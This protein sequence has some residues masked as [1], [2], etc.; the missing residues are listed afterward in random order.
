V[1]LDPRSERGDFAELRV[2]QDVAASLE[3]CAG[4]GVHD[5]VVGVHR[6]RNELLAQ[7]PNRLDRG[8]LA[9]AGYGIG[10]EE[11]ARALRIDHAL[12][13]HRE[14]KTLRRDVVA[15]AVRDGAVVPERCPAPPDR[16]EDCVFARDAEHRVLLAG[17]ARIGQVLGRCR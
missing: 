10:G 14:S 13:D 6:S 12:H 5:E 9:A 15:L 3:D 1:L 17:E 2:A 7:A 4:S 8:A 16:I 11:H